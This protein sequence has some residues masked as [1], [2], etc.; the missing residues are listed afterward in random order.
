[1]FFLY[2]SGTFFSALLVNILYHW[3][4][5]N[6]FLL[7]STPL[8]IPLVGFYRPCYSILLSLKMLCMFIHVLNMFNLN[9]KKSYHFSHV[10]RKMSL[11]HFPS[12]EHSVPGQHWSAPSHLIC[13]YCTPTCISKINPRYLLTLY[14]KK[15]I[16]L[17]HITQYKTFI[18]MI[19]KTGLHV[20]S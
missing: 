2:T 3:F 12:I 7:I 4:L 16:V 11:Q 14:L 18:Y 15:Y 20:G 9:K 8:V 10:R 19:D 6:P 13:M 5:A 1:M 17:N